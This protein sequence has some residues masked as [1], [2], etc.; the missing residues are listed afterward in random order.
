[1]VNE[2]EMK[3]KPAHL[4]HTPLNKTSGRCMM[5]IMFECGGDARETGRENLVEREMLWQIE[6]V[7]RRTNGVERGDRSIIVLCLCAKHVTVNKNI[8]HACG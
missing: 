4:I 7:A 2:Q 3:N 8:Q 5:I 1:M 6:N